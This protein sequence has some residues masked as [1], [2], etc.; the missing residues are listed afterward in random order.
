MK[1]QGAVYRTA[2]GAELKRWQDRAVA[3]NK[4]FT[5]KYPDAA[6]KIAA[7]EKSCGAGK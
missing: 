1:A 5:D 2:S 6:Q 7:L 4:A 3:G